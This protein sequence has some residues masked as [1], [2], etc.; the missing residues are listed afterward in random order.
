[1]APSKVDTLVDTAIASI[2][3]K[4]NGDFIIDP[5]ARTLVKRLGPDANEYPPDKP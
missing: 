1:M 5:E 4:G 3:S 2:P